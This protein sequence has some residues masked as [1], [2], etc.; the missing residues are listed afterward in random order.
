M[1]RIKIEVGRAQVDQLLGFEP[2]RKRFARAQA[3]Q[4]SDQVP[5]FSAADLGIEAMPAG[6]KSDEV[7]VLDV[8]NLEILGVD[9]T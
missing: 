6:G 5:T 9:E 4:L 2:V 7:P 8:A 1:A 3:N